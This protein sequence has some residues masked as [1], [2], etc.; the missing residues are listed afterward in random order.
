MVTTRRAIGIGLCLMSWSVSR[1]VRA[2]DASTT[3]AAA[4]LFDEGVALMEKGALG[5]ACPKL[6]RSH[7]L[8]PNG[9]TLL[10]LAECY[11]KS[12]KVASAWVAYKEAAIR[13]NAAKRVDAEKSAVAAAKRLEPSVSKLTVKIT[14]EAEGLTITRNGVA[15]RRPEWSVP[16]PLDPGDYRFEATA[17]GYKPWSASVAIGTT[18]SAREVVIPELEREAPRAPAQ[19]AVVAP[20]RNDERP[21][22]PPAG[23][24]ARTIGW[25]MGG[26]GLVAIGV[27][28][29]FGLRAMA[30]NDDADAHCV[31]ETSCDAQGVRLDEEGRDAGLVSTV[32][33]VGGGAALGLGT[34]LV[35]T[36]HEK[37]GPSASASVGPTRGGAAIAI[38]ARF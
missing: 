9:G 8:S 6:A 18:G 31:R 36:A 28:T 30:K 33:F 35:L 37:A 29:Y 21:V 27:G 2:Q 19:P 3:G 26:V 24:G 15:L 17:P 14:A 7:E 1:D 5:E 12:G 10:A 38:R 22:E 13:A 20:P 34:V 16:L 11:E 23:G 32:A 25:I 4:A